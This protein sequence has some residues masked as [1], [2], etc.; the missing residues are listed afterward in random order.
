MQLRKCIYSAFYTLCK[1]SFTKKQE[2]PT[3][4]SVFRE[5][6]PDGSSSKAEA[7]AEPEAEEPEGPEE[8]SKRKSKYEGVTWHI[9]GQKWY[10][11]ITNRL[12]GKKSSST[13][14]KDED[15]CFEAYTAE[16]ARETAVFE[17]EIAKRKAAN[18]LLD[19]LERAPKAED[20]LE[21]TVYWHV[22]KDTKPRYV[23]Y[24]AM[25]SGKRYQIACETC[26]KQAFPN[27]Q[28]ERP[29]F[30]ISHGG[31]G[32]TTCKCGRKRSTCRE[33][34]PNVTNMVTNCYS[35]GARLYV[36]RKTTKG[37]NGL[38][39]MCDA[40]LNKQAAA[41]GSAPPPKGKKTEDVVLDKLELLVVD[42]D[43]DLIKPE[44][45]DDFSNALGSLFEDV[46]V[47][48]G[49]RKLRKRKRGQEDCETTTFRR[50]DM[51]YVVRGRE[52]GRIVAALS[53]EVDEDSHRGRKFSCET[54]K[55]EDTYQ[56]LQKL[57]A[58]EGASRLSHTGAR[59]D[60]QL[61]YYQVF[62]INPDACDVKPPI[63]CDD[64]IKVLAKACRE[65]LTRDPAEYQALSAAGECL[66]PHVKCFYYHSKA[67]SEEGTVYLD[68]FPK[69]VP[70]WDWQGN[71]LNG[72]KAKAKAPRRG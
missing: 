8:P 28:G 35:C 23:P 27:A 50:P 42:A 18:P 14:Y 61:I 44:M 2:C 1:K 54:G 21:K 72:G 40:H 29:R 30:C 43:G 46:L 45:R 6:D 58:G 48:G 49:G 53:V 68:E 66:V 38:C 26:N 65:F 17:A 41:S 22:N 64:R 52:N 16:K 51:L 25:K 20:A 63:K 10:F 13:L 70:Q 11:R 12:T 47:D 9:K 15:E 55:V 71:V 67:K 33:C 37:G 69:L 56:A 34:N 32:A 60:A 7:E 31:G 36:K 39:S 62:K 5:M 24:R 19:G 3:A 59:A 4:P 57:A